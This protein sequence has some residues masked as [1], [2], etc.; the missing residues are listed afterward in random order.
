MA[1]LTACTASRRHI[2]AD[3]IHADLA[4]TEIGRLHGENWR[5]LGFCVMPEDVRWNEVFG[6]VAGSEDSP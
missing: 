4:V 6:A 5:I 2:F 3:S 1:L